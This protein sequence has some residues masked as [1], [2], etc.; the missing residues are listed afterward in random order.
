MEKRQYP[1]LPCGKEMFP[2]LLPWASARLQYRNDEAREYAASVYGI[3][4]TKQRPLLKS[5]EPAWMNYFAHTLA[6]MTGK[7]FKFHM[8][9]SEND[10]IHYKPDHARITAYLMA[11]PPTRGIIRR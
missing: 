10:G 6:L 1:E 3:D 2:R 9:P 4:D 5:G 7:N 11:H 8:K